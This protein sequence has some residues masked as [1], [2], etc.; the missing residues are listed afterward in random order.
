MKFNTK[1]IDI[2]ALIVYTVLKS[3]IINVH[4]INKYYYFTMIIL[5]YFVSRP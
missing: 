3:I 5:I 1:I 2:Y 4:W